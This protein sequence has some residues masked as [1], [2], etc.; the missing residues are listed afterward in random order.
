MIRHVW[1]V[2]CSRALTDR[3]SNNVSLVEVIEEIQLRVEKNA[4]KDKIAV[5][6]P[7]H[8]VTL[9]ARMEADKPSCVHAKDMVIDPS[10][11]I[12]LVKEYDVDLSEHKR[13][14]FI[15]NLQG[16]PVP[17]SGQ[18]R[19]HTQLLDEKSHAWEDVSDVPLEVTIE[20]R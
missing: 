11:E 13:Y 18:Y 14:R 1:S 6:F 4:T 16:L 3:D 9:W 2:L 20:T 5:P 7:I 17:S 8:W 15:R 12:I 10:G 19:F